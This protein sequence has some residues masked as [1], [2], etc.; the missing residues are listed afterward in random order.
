MDSGVSGDHA[1]GIRYITLRIISKTVNQFRGVAVARQQQFY[2]KKISSKDLNYS[3]E[4]ECLTSDG[5]AFHKVGATTE[6]A[7]PPKLDV[8]GG[9]EACWSKVCYE[10]RRRRE[11]VYNVMR[12]WR[13]FGESP[14]MVLNV[15][16]SVLYAI[17]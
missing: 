8:R 2:F 13:Y 11:G 16:R 15:I 4:R 1:I 7:R 10:E 9:G 14:W 6:N 12:S 3:T 5:R 17:L